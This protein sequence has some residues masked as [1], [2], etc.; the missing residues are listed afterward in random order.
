MEDRPL[1]AIIMPCCTVW[2]GSVA[3]QYCQYSIYEY[4]A[5]HLPGRVGERQ[6]EAVDGAAG[7]DERVPGRV[8]AQGSGKGRAAW[9][10]QRVP[11]RVQAEAMGQDRDRI[12]LLMRPA[13]GCDD[14]RQ[15][16]WCM[17][18]LSWLCC[19]P[20]PPAAD[21]AVYPPR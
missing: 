10:G 14:L 4:Y 11:R 13:P 17:L 3:E 19:I 12:W 1:P 6:G 8:Q 21:A 15:L 20:S 2:Q 7:R 16:R 9:Q 5:P 18:G